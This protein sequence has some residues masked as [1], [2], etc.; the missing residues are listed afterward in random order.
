MHRRIFAFCTALLLA[1]TMAASVGHAQPKAKDEL[2]IGMTQ[3]PDDAPSEHRIRCWPRPTCSNMT[4]RPFTAYDKDWKLVC[5]LCTELP[6]LENGK[7]VAE[8]LPDGKQGIAVTYTIQP[9]AKWGDGTPV[10][11]KDVL[12]TCEVGRHPAER[13][14]QRASSTAAST[15][16]TSK[17]AKTFTLHVDKLTFDYNAINDFR[18]AARAS[19]ARPLRADPADLPQPHTATTPIPTNPGLYFGPYRDRRDGA[20][21]AH[22]ARAQPDLVGQAARLP[23][24]SSSAVDREHRGAG[25]QPAVGRASTMIAGEL[26]L[27]LD[28]ALAFEKR[29]GDRV[30]RDL[31]AGPDLRAYRP[32]SRQPD[33]RGPARAPGAAARPRPRGDQPAAVRRPPAG[34]R[35]LRQSAR[36]G[37]RPTTCSSYTVDPAKAAAL[38]DEAGWTLGAGKGCAR[39]AA[40]RAAAR[41]ADDH[42]RQPHPRAGAAGAAEPVAPARHRA[43]AS[44]TSR[45]ACSSARR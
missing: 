16:S 33:P 29:H 13:R 38:L 5:M 21:L 39:N 4:R 45:R 41:R 25:G 10:T 15:R 2:I 8:D 34:G 31:Q 11:T 22:R 12:F 43:C 14:R 27:S 9:D 42:R 44:A 37:P 7:A 17:D 1:A 23:S 19:R 18:R 36:L 26:G 28:Q 3:Y 6:T 30:R 35:H 24:A 20:R 40:G 32:Q